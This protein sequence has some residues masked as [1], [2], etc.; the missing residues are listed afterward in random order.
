MFKYINIMTIPEQLDTTTLVELAAE[1]AASFKL[2]QDWMDTRMHREVYAVDGAST[3][4]RD[5][6]F[7]LSSNEEGH[8]LH[9]SIADTG[10]FVSSSMPAVTELASR[11][12]G[13][14]YRGSRALTPMIPR[15]LSERVFSLNPNRH[16][17]A[18][19]AHIPIDHEGNVFEPVVTREAVLPH[20]LTYRGLQRAI[21]DGSYEGQFT[22]LAEVSKQLFTR[23]H[24][25]KTGHFLEDEEGQEITSAES[26][27]GKFVV[28]ECMILMNTVIAEY[29]HARNIPGLYRGHT[30]AGKYVRYSLEPAAHR[31]LNLPK[32]THATSPLRRFGD[33][34]NLSNIADHID[35][36][37][38]YTYDKKTL[39]TVANRLNGVGE[40][41]QQPIFFVEDIPV[42]IRR[43]KNA[44][45]FDK[46][47]GET[48]TPDELAYIFFA[49]VRRNAL[50][51][52]Q[53]LRQHALD[54]VINNPRVAQKIV[55]EAIHNEWIKRDIPLNN[56]G[57][58]I[59]G[60]YMLTTLT[61]EYILGVTRKKDA[62]PTA[63]AIEVLG[64][65]AGIELNPVEL[66]QQ[67]K[68]D[69]RLDTAL[70]DGDKYLR[71]MDSKTNIGYVTEFTGEGS[72]CTATASVLVDGKQRRRQ[73]RGVNRKEA[74]QNAATQLIQDLQLV[75]YEPATP[76]K[77]RSRKK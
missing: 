43:G 50:D 74:L 27:L 33:F 6:G 13:T 46:L 25:D 56:N 39:A 29:M 38:S 28:Q 9:V 76:V 14:M 52:R 51:D 5:D 60:S 16:R 75:E 22:R 59:A 63:L 62:T 69:A 36:S 12:L 77:G 35:R 49:P 11:R 10:S 68:V 24:P 70:K 19:T 17:P 18:L 30:Q 4:D 73:G 65:A 45:L 44:E 34:V 3:R 72:A 53:E 23:R 47:A 20:V 15:T 66:T 32:Y 64:K 55:P 42:A 48:I 61:G 31:G 37:P 58:P 1:E 57:K 71:G 2:P 8:V 7:T 26:Q 41:S 54:Y 21:E 67:F 40:S